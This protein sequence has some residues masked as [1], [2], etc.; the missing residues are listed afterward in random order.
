MKLFL[1]APKWPDN[2]L[3]G[4]IFF[5]FPFLSLSMLAGM[6]DESWDITIIDENVQ[7]ID[8]DDLPD[9]VGISVMT[10]LA[11]RSYAIADEYR[12]RNVPVIL[13]GIHPTMLPAEAAEHADCVVTGEAEPIWPQVLADA[14]AAKL[15]PRYAANNLHPLT[16]LG[17]PRR[18][19]LNRKG[20]FFINTIQTTRGCPFDCEFCSVTA[21]YGRTYRTRP[22]AEIIREVEQMD[23]SHIFFVDDNIV[24]KSAF[25][26]ELFQALKPL[27][28]QWFSQAS[29]SIVE[30]R[31]L[32]KMAQ[33]SGCGGLFVGFESLC[34][35]T[36]KAYGKS[37][38]RSAEYRDAV[39]QIHDH[40]IGI[41]GSFIFGA[42]QDDTAVFSDVLRFVEKAHIEAAIFS[43]LTPFPGTEI[44]S[45]LQ[46]D[47]R[48]LSR[49]WERYDMNHVV[50]KPK[51]MSAAQLQTGLNWAY[52]KLYGYPSILKRLYPFKRGP[53]FYGVQNI[54]F[55]RAWAKA[56]KGGLA[57]NGVEGF[58]D[59]LKL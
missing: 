48:I 19:L 37:M 14:K 45:A 7:A 21:F 54:G 4:Q 40:G 29:L 36:L 25:A 12:K 8:F 39:K 56:Q 52:K 38:N 23:G 50:F 35:E 43:V 58:E 55:K 41:Q 51:R 27:K 22:V 20:Y 2:S 11:P 5:R 15:K 24:G 30:D 28:K 57:L 46:R 32:L 47:H 26:K 10:P 3:W 33:E 9:L 53:I 49:N 42:D 34:Q 59:S 18:D 16:D 1:I 6:S 13:G 31:Q 44:F 17:T